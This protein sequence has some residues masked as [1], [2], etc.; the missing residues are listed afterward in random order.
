MRVPFAQVPKAKV[1][2]WV[3]AQEKLLSKFGQ[4]F[5]LRVLSGEPSLF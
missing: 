1:G 4:F 2:K 3:D 5:L